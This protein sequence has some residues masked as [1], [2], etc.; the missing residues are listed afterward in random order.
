M[1]IEAIRTF[2]ILA[3]TK[4]YTKT[5]D[6]LFVAQSTV[7][8]RI[9]ELER[10][11]GVRLYERTNRRV[12]LTPE[13]ER[14][15]IYAEKVIGLTDT[16]LSEMSK[17]PRYERYL[18]IGSADSIYEGHLAQ[19]LLDYRNSHPKDSLKITIGLTDHLLEQIQDELFDV[20][21]TYRPI[22]KSALLC[23]VYKQDELVLV[24][25]S[26][27]TK[28]RGGITEAELSPER[29]LMCNFA[30]Q[31]V[32][33][34][35]R[36]LFPKYHRFAFEIDDCMKIVPYLLNS[37]TYTFLPQDMAKP[38]IAEGRLLRIPLKDFKPPVI[39]SYIICRK[40]AEEIC[41]EIFG[42]P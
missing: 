17:I 21:F 29:Y 34:Y 13:G 18:R 28:Y 8:N 24:T 39:N 30:L 33:Q 37:D 7:T 25:D 15:R 3:D 41:R 22:K 14:F 16:S 6:Q 2:L 32:G 36:T 1:D 11:L 27:N 31:D 9:L 12:Y 42:Q 20:V 10:E 35:I 4:N 40:A 26:A 23:S 19:L 38:Y 5:A